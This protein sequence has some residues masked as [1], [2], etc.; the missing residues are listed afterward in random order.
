MEESD[1][2]AL[3]DAGFADEAIVHIT[4]IVSYFN[5]VNRMALALGA[6]LED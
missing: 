6:E 2:Q 3:R 5:F 1:I 4:E